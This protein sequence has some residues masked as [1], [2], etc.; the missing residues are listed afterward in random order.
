MIE[1]GYE[2]ILAICTP[3]CGDLFIRGNEQCEDRNQNW[4]DG[5]FE[6][7]IE[8][9][10]ECTNFG[11]FSSCELKNV[12]GDKIAWEREECDSTEGCDER[13]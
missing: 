3:I 11:D 12:C 4:G 8:D 9:L 1:D 10:W 13:C 6:C 7:W 5:C 2:C